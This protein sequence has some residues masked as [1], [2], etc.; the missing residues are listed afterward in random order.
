MIQIKIEIYEENG[1]VKVTRET[2]C[3]MTTDGEELAKGVYDISFD[4][5]SE[6]FQNLVERFTKDD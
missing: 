5:A 3:S 4:K 2:V 6:I 1:I